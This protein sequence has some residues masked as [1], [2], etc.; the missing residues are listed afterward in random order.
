MPQRYTVA[1][2]TLRGIA[3]SIR[4]KLRLTDSIG[5]DRLAEYVAAFPTREVLDMQR[6]ENGVT[7]LVQEGLATLLPPEGAVFSEISW[8]VLVNGVQIWSDGGWN[9][10]FRELPNGAGRHD[11]VG[12]GTAYYWYNGSSRYLSTPAD[13]RSD[14]LTQRLPTYETVLELSP[15]TIT[16]AGYELKNDIPCIYVESTDADTVLR[17][18]VG[19]DSGLLVSAEMLRADEVI[20]RMTSSSIQSPCPAGAIFRLPDGTIL[21]NP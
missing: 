15:D 14:D 16:A 11:L 1:A 6:D 3:D 17:Y 2:S 10:S 13:D 20:Y 8:R 7:M 5:G 4:Q 9:H 19:V 12:D 21:H 18:W